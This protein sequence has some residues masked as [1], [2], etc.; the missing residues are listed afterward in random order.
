MDPCSAEARGNGYRPF[1]ANNFY[2]QRR[3]A[4]SADV[5][6]ID[7]VSVP[8]L[9][10]GDD[11]VVASFNRAAADAQLYQDQD[12]LNRAVCRFAAAAL[13]NG[14]GLILVHHVVPG[15]RRA[16]EYDP[17]GRR[18]LLHLQEIRRFACEFLML[19]LATDYVIGLIRSGERC[20]VGDVGTRTTR[21]RYSCP[22]IVLYLRGQLRSNTNIPSLPSISTI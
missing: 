5:I 20:Q 4:L 11:F 22:A 2:P 12:F 17:N 18:I 3:N 19:A 10:L 1:G 13:A 6:R 21:T 16:T 9:V 14:E 15:V 8:I 7:A